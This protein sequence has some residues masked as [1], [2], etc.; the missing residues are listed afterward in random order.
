MP[1]KKILLIDDD[2]AIHTV[3]RATA[4]LKAA[5]EHMLPEGPK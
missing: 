4:E 5:V 1:G 3:L 2:K